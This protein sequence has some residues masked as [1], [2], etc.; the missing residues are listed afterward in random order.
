MKTLTTP[1]K[2]RLEVRLSADLKEAAT[3]AA[4]LANCDVTALVARGLARE[5]EEVKSQFGTLWLD[6]E[7]FQY[8]KELAEEVRP[9]GPKL[10]EAALSLDK[11]GFDFEQ[12]PSTEQPGPRP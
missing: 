2:A 3:A 5:I 11:E 8:F 6:D 7:R 1:A 9:I 12:V 10:R 4:A